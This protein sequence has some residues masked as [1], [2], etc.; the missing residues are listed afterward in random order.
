MVEQST[1]CNLTSQ[2]F[3]SK[4]KEQEEL[5]TELQQQNEDYQNMEI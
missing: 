3:V 4:M 1:E 5:I 2:S